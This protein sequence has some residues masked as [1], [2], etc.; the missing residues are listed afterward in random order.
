MFSHATHDPAV[1]SYLLEQ[2]A[3]PNPGPGTGGGIGDS[4]S[5]DLVSNSGA[6]FQS[7]A[8]R[9]SIESVDF[10]LAH[11]AV[12]SNAAPLHAAVEG[13]SLEMMSH[14]LSLGVDVDQPDSYW[15]MGFPSY[16]TPLL[17]AIV[18]GKV[19]A[20]KFLLDHGASTTKRTTRYHGFKTALELVEEQG[21]SIDFRCIV[22]TVGQR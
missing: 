11:G 8:R 7:A 14:L 3:N 1:V 10:L 9:G 13:E 20:V 4:R 2:G 21:V 5:F 6:V 19:A 17:R 15:T 22:E 18:K 12:L 16:T